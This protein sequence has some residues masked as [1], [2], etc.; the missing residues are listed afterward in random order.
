MHIEELR[1]YCLQK[2]GVTE[3]L[4]FGPDTLVFRVLGKIFL[5]TNVEANPLR[6]NAKCDPERAIDLR[7]RYDSIQPG[8]HMNKQH[9]NTIVVDGT[10]PKKLITEL[11]DHSYELIRDSLPKKLRETLS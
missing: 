3:D 1:E 7:G 6:F 4:P 2:P 5:L 9:W 11:I 10:L 8:Y